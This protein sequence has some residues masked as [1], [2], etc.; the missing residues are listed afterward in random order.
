MNSDSIG[1]REH[2]AHRKPSRKSRRGP[3]VFTNDEAGI[4]SDVIGGEG[5]WTVVG[6]TNRARVL[7]VVL[8]IRHIW[9]GS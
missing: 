2:R 5:R 9:Y 1:M 3:A 6:G 7:I 4:D 8:T